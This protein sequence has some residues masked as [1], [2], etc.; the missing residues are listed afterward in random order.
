MVSSQKV[1]KDPNQ[2]DDAEIE[3]SL[4]SDLRSAES[5]YEDAKKEFWRICSECA[6]ESVP[7]GHGAVREAF[8]RQSI[9]SAKV[10]MVTQRLSGFLKAVSPAAE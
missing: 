1:P 6:V 2:I 9:A 7:S 4:R 5:R 10:V 8:L 3:A